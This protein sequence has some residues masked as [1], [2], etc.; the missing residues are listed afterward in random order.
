MAKPRKCNR[1]PEDFYHPPPPK[2]RRRKP[3]PPPS[4]PQPGAY[5][6]WYGPGLPLAVRRLAYTPTAVSGSDPVRKRVVEPTAPTGPPD[7]VLPE[8]GT[9]TRRLW[10]LWLRHDGV[11]QR[12]GC[13]T[14]PVFV[15]NQWEW[16]VFK[17]F[18]MAV[19]PDCTA[20]GIATIQHVLPRSRGG[21]NH[22]DNLTLYCYNCNND[23]N[24]HVEFGAAMEVLPG[25][26]PALLIERQLEG[27][28]RHRRTSRQRD[29]DRWEDDGGRVPPDRD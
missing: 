24:V 5:T 28:F 12:C 14:V 6:G 1:R 8:G 16:E 2:P 17:P 25:N 27:R 9:R 11:C 21:T 15:A 23:D 22:A 13:E 26:D 3:P 19:A 29:L 18:G 10:T 20:Y 7:L 4:P